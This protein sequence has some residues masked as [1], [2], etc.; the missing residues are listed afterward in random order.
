MKFI[1][2][3]KGQSAIIDDA[4]YE[5]LNQFRWFVKKDGYAIAWT[6][7]NGKRKWLKMHRLVV[8]A[9]PSEM[10]DHVDKNKLNNQRANLRICSDSQNKQNTNKKVGQYTSKY[11]GVSWQKRRRKW[12]A[13]VT[14]GGR[15]IHLGSYDQELEAAQ[16]YDSEAKKIF[17][18]FASLNFNQ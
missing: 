11:K 8:A 10:V 14:I 9:N 6:R 18:V 4:D 16:K 1:P 7:E 15:K 12:H 13:Y 5:F 17:G 3:T 2:L